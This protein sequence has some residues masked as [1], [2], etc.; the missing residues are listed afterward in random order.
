MKLVLLL[1]G[2]V[3]VMYVILPKVL[4]VPWKPLDKRVHANAGRVEADGT[5]RWWNRPMGKARG[6]AVLAVVVVALFLFTMWLG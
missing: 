2:L 4:D 1:V 5:V 3:V 6:F